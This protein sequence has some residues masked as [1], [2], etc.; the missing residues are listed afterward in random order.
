MSW[1]IGVPAEAVL[2]GT[3]APTMAAISSILAVCGFGMFASCLQRSVK[4][5][6]HAEWLSD[7]LMNDSISKLMAA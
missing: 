6:D 4:I 7:L 2:R 3:E 5:A 1:K